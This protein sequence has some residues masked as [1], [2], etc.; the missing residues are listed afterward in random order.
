MRLILVHRERDDL[1]FEVYAYDAQQQ[2][3]VLA[4]PSVI[5]DTPFVVD[6]WIKQR[7]E[8]RK[9]KKEERALFWHEGSDCFVEES[10]PQ[11]IESCRRNPELDEVTGEYVWELRYLKTKCG[12]RGYVER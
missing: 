1:W 10:T 4:G 5:S 11:G 2:R 12:R 7:Y 9:V 3:A 6:D 8:L